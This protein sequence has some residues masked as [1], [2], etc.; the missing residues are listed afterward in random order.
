MKKCKLNFLALLIIL[1]SAININVATAITID[2]AANNGGCCFGGM[3][4]YWFETPIDLT[5][6]NAWLNTANGLSTSYNLEVLAL[7]V[8][9]PLFTNSTSN[10]S[11]LASF[12]NLNGVA[13]LNISFSANDIVGLLAW[14]NNLALTPYSDQSLQNIGGNAITFNRLLRQNLTPGDP[15]SDELNYPI[16]AIGFTYNT[17]SLS[18]S[19]PE[20]MLLLGLAIA[21]VGFAKRKRGNH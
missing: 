4:G 16:G 9:P 10:Y 13:A 19:E 17:N 15:I 11:T 2:P 18:V 5:L 14:D 21:A 12:N 7:N 3:R 8:T 6:N 20:I 1:V